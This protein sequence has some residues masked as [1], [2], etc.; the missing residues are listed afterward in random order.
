MYDDDFDYYDDDG[1]TLDSALR[2]HPG[3]IAPQ[4]LGDRIQALLDLSDCDWAIFKGSVVLM[5]LFGFGSYWIMTQTAENNPH[6]DK[7]LLY[8]MTAFFAAMG[9]F[10]STIGPTH[11]GST[12]PHYWE[13]PSTLRNMVQYRLARQRAAQRA[14]AHS[15]PMITPT[16]A[17]LPRR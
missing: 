1:R 2:K 13:K 11:T 4:T 8:I 10:M 5:P 7:P 15:V 12:G 3:L 16:V 9:W 6:P 17:L 14:Q